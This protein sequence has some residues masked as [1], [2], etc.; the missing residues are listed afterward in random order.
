LTVNRFGCIIIYADNNTTSNRSAAQEKEDIMIVTFGKY[1]GADTNT[2]ARFSEGREYLAWGSEKLQSEKWRN[3]FGRALSSVHLSSVSLEEQA[4]LTVQFDKDGDADY[5]DILRFL[6]D[7]EAD[8]EEFAAKEKAAEEK[9][10]E[11]FKEWEKESKKPISQ[12]RSIF[13]R[14][15]WHGRE[16]LESIQLS[17]FSSAQAKEQLIKYIC[18][19]QQE[20]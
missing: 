12:L 13:K 17:N 3:E 4:R 14:F 18:R 9:R 5:D 15:E 6:R 19:L 16:D 2:L 8:N 11:I 1:Q 20:C 10:L 7:E